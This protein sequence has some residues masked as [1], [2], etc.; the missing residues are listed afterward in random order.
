[1]RS[2]AATPSSFRRI[3]MS[4]RPALEITVILR[5]ALRSRGRRTISSLCVDKAEHP[6]AQQLMSICD[7][8]DS[9]G[10]S[11]HGARR[12]TA[13]E[14]GLRRRPGNADRRR[15]RD[16][17][18]GRR[19][20]EHAD[21]QDAEPRSGCSCDGNLLVEATVYD[22]FLELLQKEGGYLASRGEGK[23]E[24]GDVG[25][26][27]PRTLDTVA[28]AGRVIAQKAGFQLPAGRSSSS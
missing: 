9:T 10:G 7:L 24:R 22:T 3:P 11:A 8:D 15:R 28:R 6:L 27:G 2:S 16:R 4:T 13:P 20:D 12:R 19:G 17:G 26:R 1:M 5:A 21:Q 14:A 18:S 25:R 23:L